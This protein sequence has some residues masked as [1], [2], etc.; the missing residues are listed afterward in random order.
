MTYIPTQVAQQQGIEE[1][2]DQTLLLRK[3]EK[4]LST[5]TDLELKEEDLDDSD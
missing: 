1:M 4:H 3:M 5:I 2:Q